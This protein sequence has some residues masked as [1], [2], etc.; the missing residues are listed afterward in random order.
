M[1]RRYPNDI[2]LPR[3]ALLAAAAYGVGG[4]AC[5]TVSAAQSAAL[6]PG[7][8]LLG[9]VED[10][11]RSAFPE[12]AEISSAELA[13]AQTRDRAL[14]LIDVRAADEYRMSR[15]VGAIHAHPDA[16]RTADFIATVGSLQGRTIVAYCS[17]G[18]RSARLI[19]RLGQGLRDQG[20]TNV[21]NLTGGLFRWRNERR[22][23]VDERGAATMSIH[24]YNALWRQLLVEAP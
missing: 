1:T 23:M 10:Q 14:V 8:G 12:V 22:P 9:I 18:L 24:P 3:R 19:V 4:F 5:A 13:A 6:P 21:L 2:S 15:L 16:R 7:G 20:A 11:I 17:I